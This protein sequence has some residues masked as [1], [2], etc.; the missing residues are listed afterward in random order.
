M[1]SGLVVVGQYAGIAENSFQGQSG[2]R[3]E[4]VKV[5]VHDAV[6]FQYLEVGAIGE[7]SMRLRVAVEAMK[8]GQAVA[9][10]VRVAKSGALTFVNVQNV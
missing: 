7:D 5:K 10:G 1:L 4:Q 2:D 3:I 6:N 9:L 8:P